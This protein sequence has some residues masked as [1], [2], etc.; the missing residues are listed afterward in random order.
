MAEF[1]VGDHHIC[2]QH[3]ADRPAGLLQFRE[4]SELLGEFGCRLELTGH[5]QSGGLA[6]ADR[7]AQ[8]PGVLGVH[9][10]LR[11]RLDLVEAALP[12]RGQR[13]RAGRPSHR[14]VVGRR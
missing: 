10:A 9:R 1:A 13:G 12:R 11:Q 8:Q 3:L 4:I 2:Q 14:L 7:E 6:K 5:H